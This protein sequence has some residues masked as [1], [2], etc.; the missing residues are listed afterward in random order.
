MPT[1]HR[2]ARELAFLH[3]FFEGVK[4]WPTSDGAVIKRAFLEAS[5]AGLAAM[6]ALHVAAASLLDA[7][8]LVT[9]E[10]RKRALH[11]TSSISVHTI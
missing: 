7:D 4:Y 3:A 1:Y 11:R 8:Q 5:E 10:K 2:R 6:D 9:T